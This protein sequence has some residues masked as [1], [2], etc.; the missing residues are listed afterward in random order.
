MTVYVPNIGR[1]GYVNL[2]NIPC[3]LSYHDDKKRK[4]NY[5]IEAVLLSDDDKWVGINQILS[6]RLVEYFLETNQLSEMMDFSD[7][8]SI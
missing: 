3:L 4:Y 2:K 6:N 7:S 5:D 8:E 1:I